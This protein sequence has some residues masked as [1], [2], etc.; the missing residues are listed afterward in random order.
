M[1]KILSL[2]IETR[3][4]VVYTF[5]AYDTTIN[6]EQVIEPGGVMCFAAKWVGERPIHFWSE[7]NAG[8]EGMLKALSELLDQADAVLTYNGNRFD[9]PKIQ[10]EFLL[11][12]LTPPAPVTSIDV[13]KTIKKMGFMINKL[14]YIGPLLRLGSKLKHEG[15]GL[16]RSVCEGD[17]KAQARMEKY[18]KQ[19]VILLEK[20]YLRVK[21]YIVNHPHL[22]LSKQECGNCES[23]HTQSRGWRRTK[24]F[25][26]QRLQ[27]QDCGAW[28]DG[29]RE[30]IT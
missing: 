7:W 26:T 24:L 20:L 19:D 8:R 16:W 25:R 2:D 30:A 14:A 9:L 15:F 5:Q 23:T 18:N 27:C 3:P 1:S 17:V 11:A 29:R 22:G 28:S 4:A 6:P 12:G 13:L 21:P 10:G